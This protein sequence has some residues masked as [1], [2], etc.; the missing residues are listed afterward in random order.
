MTPIQHYK[1]RN[2]HNYLTSLFMLRKLQNVHSFNFFQL[3]EVFQ[4]PTEHIRL[5]ICFHG[6]Q[7]F[8]KEMWSA[9]QTRLVTNLSF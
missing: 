7:K 3:S 5:S 6:S 2:N 4:Q 9:S 1:R 8:A